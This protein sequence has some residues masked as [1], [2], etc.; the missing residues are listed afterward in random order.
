MFTARINALGLSCGTDS[1]GLSATAIAAISLGC[2]VGAI[3]I[4]LAGFII[5]R[6]M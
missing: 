1:E 4:A 3:I 5:H 2:I 6:R